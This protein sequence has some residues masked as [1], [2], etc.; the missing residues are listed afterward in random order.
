MTMRETGMVQMVENEIRDRLDN[1]KERDDRGN[2][3]EDPI[4]GETE[5]NSTTK[6]QGERPRFTQLFASELFHIFLSV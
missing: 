3:E 6:D 1:H 5:S 2:Y 4:H